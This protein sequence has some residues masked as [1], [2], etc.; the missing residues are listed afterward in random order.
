M[1]RGRVLLIVLG[2][3]V[4]VLGL[5]YA[6]GASGRLSVERTLDESRQELDVAEARGAILDA[7]VA[8]YNNN[9]GEASRRL[10]DA[11]E[12][13]RRARQRYQDAG[14]SRAA[15]GVDAALTHV[16]EAQRLAGRLDPAANTRAGEALDAIKV[17]RDNVQ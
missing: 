15:A 12:P 8:L 16:E 9:F 7:R 13:L 11:K 10:D 4:V 1:T 14:Q 2:T 6:W 17:A 3:L 5:G